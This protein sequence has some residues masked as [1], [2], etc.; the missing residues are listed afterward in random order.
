MWGQGVE[1]EDFESA[2]DTFPWLGLWPIL[3]GID[4][5]GRPKANWGADG[6]IGETVAERCMR[7]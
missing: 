2:W 1:I 5:G 3:G 4:Y 6:I 7:G